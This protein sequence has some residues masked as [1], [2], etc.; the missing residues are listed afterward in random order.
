[1]KYAVLGETGLEVSAVSFGTAPLGDMFGAA[2]AGSAIAAVHDAI[3]AGINLF[4]SSPYYGG[5][6]AEE[7][8]GSALKDVPDPVLV[9]TK[10]G[11]YGFDEFDF[12]PTRIREGFH[13]SLRLLQRDHVDILQLHDIE[14][15]SLGGVFEDAYAELVR[16]KDEGK[17]RFIGMTGYPLHTLRRAVRETDLDVVLNY[18][19]FTLLNTELTDGL[20]PAAEENGTAVINAAAVALGLLTPGGLKADVPAG[21]AVRAAADR[22]REICLRRGADISFLAN[23]FAIQRSG[24]ATTLIGTT[25]AHHLDS[26]VRAATT[27]IDEDLLAEVLA[28]TAAVHAESWPSGLPENN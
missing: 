1:M 26:A 21:D 20:L 7:R 23:Q 13:H 28:A 17:C 19:H 16:L 25:K 12:S 6:L 14:F 2:D 8:L 5:G 4:D 9:A 27:P 18:A 24:C 22:A 15:V 11:R 10:A 3:D